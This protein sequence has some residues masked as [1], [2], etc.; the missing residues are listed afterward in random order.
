MA[1][2]HVTVKLPD[3]KVLHDIRWAVVALD[4][5]ARGRFTCL[6]QAIAVQRMLVRRD[7]PCAVVIGAKLGSTL[8]PRTTG[9][10]MSA[11]AWIRAGG[12]IVVGEKESN[13]FAP[14]VSYVSNPLKIGGDGLSGHCTTCSNLRAGDRKPNVFSRAVVQMICNFIQLLLRIV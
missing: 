8:D 3:N 11:H 6:M 5:T 4:R 13:Q 10:P 7:I 12:G 1:G 9:D 2:E 14:I